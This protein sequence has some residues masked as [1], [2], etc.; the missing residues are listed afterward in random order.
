MC[1]VSWVLSPF[2][3]SC[4]ALFLN[5]PLWLRNAALAHLLSDVASLFWPE[6]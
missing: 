1:G 6:A 5:G 3:V 2:L 4:I